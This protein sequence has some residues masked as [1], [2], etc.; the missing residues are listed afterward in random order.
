MQAPTSILRGPFRAGALFLAS[1]ALALLAGPLPA[2]APSA[3]S[4]AGCGEIVQ[5]ITCPKLFL[6]DLGA[7]WLLDDYGGFGVGDSVFVTGTADPSCIS[8]CMQ[9]NGCITG[10]TIAACPA[11]PT[12]PYC[13]CASGAPCGNTDPT[14][15]CTNAAGQGGLLA[16]SGSVSVSADDLFLAASQLPADA[17]GIFFM[18]GAPTQAP[19]GNGQR[20]VDP[21]SSG[22]YRFPVLNSGA[23]GSFAFGPIV[24]HATASFP[25]AGQILPG[26][27]WYFQGW[28]RDVGGPCGAS[29]NLTN[30]TQADF[31][32]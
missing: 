5:G 31:L 26:S 17:V 20:C 2:S 18:G 15:G 25:P 13:F 10:T 4:Y 1:A 30:A 8:I 21:G 6:D 28:Y 27:T 23:S 7:L 16:G 3:G 9:G 24:G 12:I 32:P 29:H 19:F 22:L 11:D 14:A